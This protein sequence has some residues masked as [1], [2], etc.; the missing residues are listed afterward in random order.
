MT[1]DWPGRAYRLLTLARTGERF[2]SFAP[3]VPAM[4]ED[5]RAAFQARLASGGS[6]L[7]LAD[8]SAI[9]AVPLPPGLDIHSHPDR[10]R[11]G[12]L[13][14]YA[15]ST[16][17]GPGVWLLRNGRLE[18][19]ARPHGP[20][21]PTIN[22]AGDV[23]YRARTELGV[24]AIFLARGERTLKIA[25]IGHRIAGFQG[26]P[27]VDS[28]GSVAFRADLRGGGQA[29]FI[30][31]GAGLREVVATGDRFTAL[32]NFPMLDESGRLGFVAALADGQFAAFLAGSGGPECFLESGRAFESFRGVLINRAGP[33]ALIATPAAGTLGVFTGP[34]PSRH[35]LLAIDAPMLGSTIAEFALNPVSVN[36][37]GQIAARIRLADGTELILR[38]D[39]A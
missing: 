16:D 14:F 12:D 24:E 9:D 2:A 32:A 17:A 19:L 28:A 7:F 13:A 5:G 31:D 34:D 39:P 37:A 21:G 22:E 1:F 35:T 29:I 23:A 4:G 38:A 27:V 36:E 20:L 3:Y 33:V 8:E 10:A 6:G 18:L 26:L 15:H 25:E 11:S 30:G